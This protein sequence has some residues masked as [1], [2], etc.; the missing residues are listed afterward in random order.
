MRSYKLYY[1][2]SRGRAE[3]ARWLFAQ[4]DVKYEDVRLDKEAWMKKK[5]EFPFGQMP[6]LEVEDDA[7]NVHIIPQSQTINRFL[8]R[9]LGLDG[10]SN[11]DSARGDFLGEQMAD[12][13]R[14]LPWREP[15]EEKRNQLMKEAFEGPLSR[16]LAMIEKYV[17]DSGYLVC[18]EVTVADIAFT[19]GADVLMMT[20]PN[21]LEKTPKLKALWQKVRSLP[22]IAAWIKKRPETSF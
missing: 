6:V 10:K 2:N 20:D 12:A 8:A 13:M 3:I 9:E 4:A 15:N 19:V 17:L 1:F 22:R 16:S 5:P 7:G 14:D 18:S 11:L 21:I